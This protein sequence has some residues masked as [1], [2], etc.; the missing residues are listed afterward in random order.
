MMALVK[1]P[2]SVFVDF[3]L[4]RQCG[5]PMDADLQRNILRDALEALVQVLKPGELIDLPYSWG[6]PF[7]WEDYERDLAEML[8]RRDKPV[9]AWPS[10]K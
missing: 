6:E 10:R 1:A 5:K 3:P 2:R 8:A 4:G 9:Q 7:A